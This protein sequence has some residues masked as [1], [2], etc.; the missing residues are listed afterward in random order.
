M[1]PAEHSLGLAEAMTEELEDYLLSAE[2]FWPLQRRAGSGEPPYPKL[3]LGSLFLTLDELEASES[4]LAPALAARL[5][6]LRSR[7]EALRSKWAAAIQRKAAQELKSRVNLWRAYLTDLEESPRAAELFPQEARQ[8][9]M[10]ARLEAASGDLPEGASSR[11]ALQEVDSR[12][13]QR[14]NPGAFIW[15]RRLAR[16]YPA[17][18]FWFLYGTP[19]GGERS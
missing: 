11:R 8:R 19:G 12:L 7:V 17:S 18:E 9:V 5:R 4:D 1:H 13:R 6:S 16:V 15:D 14:F 2:L 10:A 3:S